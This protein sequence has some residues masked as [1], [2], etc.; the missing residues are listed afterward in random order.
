MTEVM[1]YA[2]TYT[3]HSGVD[4][5]PLGMGSPAVAPYG[6]YPTADGQTVVLGT[7]NDREWQ[8]VAREIIDRPDLADDP[9]FAHQRRTAVSTGT[10]STR[11]S[12]PGAP[13]HDLADMQDIAD[14][15]GIGN[16]RYNMPS[17]VIAH[18]HLTARDRWRKIDTPAG[19]SRRCC[20]RR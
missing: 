14:A 12:P 15:A 18:P 6:A 10:S 17:D 4:Q 19:A 7:T 20:R 2:L 16:S 11:R 5:Q 9:R 8:R 1:G 13:Q 3:R